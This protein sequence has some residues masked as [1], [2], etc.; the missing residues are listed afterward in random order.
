MDVLVIWKDGTK[1]VV[2]TSE[3]RLIRS[4]E[5][6]V[7]ASVKMKY[8][9]IWYYGKIIATEND[10]TVYSET[11]HV[12]NLSKNEHSDNSTDEEEPLP[13]I[14]N[15]L[16]K[17]KRNYEEW[18]TSDEEP[19]VRLK[20]NNNYVQSCEVQ[21][22]KREVFSSCHRCYILLCWEHFIEDVGE[23]DECKHYNQVVLSNIGYL[24]QSF[25]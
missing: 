18:D 10:N 23:G 25:N 22:C 24:L 8:D 7:G 2:S 9:N 21:S 17:I 20:E 6:V 12:S 15:K 5:F 14:K 19:L 16:G 13:V 4:S 3:L 1:N 11:S